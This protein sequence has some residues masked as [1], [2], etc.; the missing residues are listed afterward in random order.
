ME[1]GGVS[2]LTETRSLL[3]TV[4]NKHCI[5]WGLR[6]ENVPPAAVWRLCEK[7]GVGGGGDER[8]GKSSQASRVED[9]GVDKG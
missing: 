9:V 8:E 2:S 6:R 3:I 5:V 7:R 1:A 4:N